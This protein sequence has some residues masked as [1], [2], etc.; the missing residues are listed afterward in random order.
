MN[1]ESLALVAVLLVPPP[2][3]A[4]EAPAVGR[5]SHVRVSATSVAKRQE[6]QVESIDGTTLTLRSESRSMIALPLGTV[7][8]LE[9]A[10][11][12]RGHARTGALIGAGFG[13]LSLAA[14][15]QGENCFQSSGDYGTAALVTATTTA[16]GAL[17]GA[18]I[19]S[20]RWIVIPTRPPSARWRPGSEPRRLAGGI[21]IAFSF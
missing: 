9:V 15:C 8:S 6:G 20:D 10:I 2:L 11:G 12:R 14:L 4:E 17:I 3:Q 18:L 21:A 1:R 16:C 5:G 13:V 19:K 7:T